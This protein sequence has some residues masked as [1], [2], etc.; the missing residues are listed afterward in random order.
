MIP[1]RLKR[2]IRR[3]HKK[4]LKILGDD[5]LIVG[6]GCAVRR[7]RHL[8]YPFRQDSDFLYLTG[9]PE[10][11]A[12]FLLDPLNDTDTAT[13]F[14]K[15]KNRREEVWQGFAIGV[16][17][18][19]AHF[20]ID[21]ARDTDTLSD[22]LVPRLADRTVHLIIPDP[23]P[24]RETIRRLIDDHGATEAIPS[25]VLDAIHTLRTVKTPWEIDQIKKAVAITGEAHHACM[26]AASRCQS[27]Y[28]LAAEFRYACGMAG[29]R[30][31]A[32]ET[33]VASGR[34]CTCQHYVANDAALEPDALV[35]IDGGAEWNGYAAD[36]TRTFP[37]SGTFS[38]IQK[39]LYSVVLQA[40]KAAIETVA[41]DRT[42]EEVHA[43]AARSFV[44]GLKALKLLHGPTDD[45]LEKGAYRD[46]WPASVAHP[47]GLCV[48]DVF[49]KIPRDGATAPRKLKPGMVITVEP[50]FYAQDFN[51]QVPDAFR[52]IGIRIEDDI[53]ITKDRVVDLSAH[54][55]REIADVETM[56]RG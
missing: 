8:T 40:Q 34:R 12:V 7:N 31:V 36:L 41:V 16:A 39:D 49:P 35:L 50:G 37:L 45:I 17:A 33:I 13:L 3:R 46:F 44:D 2:D 19:E 51:H 29:A 54:V 9:F 14:V 56:V 55:A 10:Q 27:E 52:N 1:T 5:L 48:H 6:S 18:A 42:L 53:L 43:A 30:D 20:P 47:L 23:H 24:A 38:P 25:P 11:G 22:V 28:Q 26:R 15:K 4:L 21:K 32:F